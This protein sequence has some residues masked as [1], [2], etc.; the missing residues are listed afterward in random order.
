[1]DRNNL[2]VAMQIANPSYV[3]SRRAGAFFADRH[4]ATTC[5]SF[6]ASIPPR[7]SGE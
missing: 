2:S 4:M 5:K 6:L 7:R 1:M 3:A